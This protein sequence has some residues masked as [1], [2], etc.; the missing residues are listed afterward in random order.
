[1]NRILFQSSIQSIRYLKSISSFLAGASIAIRLTIKMQLYAQDAVSPP[2][3][4]A[5]IPQYGETMF[6]INGKTKDH[7]SL[8]AKYLLNTLVNKIL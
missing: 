7:H 4:L 3:S 6:S 2:A 1:M 8:R 5:K